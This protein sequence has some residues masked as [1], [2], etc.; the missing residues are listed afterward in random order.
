MKKFILVMLSIAMLLPALTYAQGVTSGAFG[1]AVIDVDGK[2]MPGVMVKALHIPTGTTYRVITNEKG[3][4]NIQGAVVGGPYK[5]TAE[6]EGFTTGVKDGLV[7]KLGEKK[8]LQ[9]MLQLGTI[10]EADIN[11][12]ASNPIIN[13]SRTGAA[14]NVSADTIMNLP[15]ISRSISD[16]TRLAPQFAS[17][18]EEGSFS[19]GGRSS[20]Y[21]NIQIDG[22]QNN[23]LFGLGD[24]GA[25]G[26]R[27]ESAPISLDAIQEFQIVLAP[28]DVRHGG[29]TGGGVNVIT[30]SGTNK[31]HGSAYFFGRNQSLVGNGPDD[32]AYS[33]MQESTIGLSIGGAI[34]KNK[35]F[36]FLS[37]EQ[38]KA[39]DK[40]DLD[41]YIDGSGNGY[42][43]GNKEDADRIIAAL[44]N[45]GYDA[46]GYGPLTNAKKNTKIFFRFDW[47][48]G[49]KHRLTLRHNF[50]DASK[51]VR[52]N[53][54][55]YSFYLE[56][57]GVI[58]ESKTNST[59]L[60]LMSTFSS[61]LFNE[62][63]LN[64]TTI[65][66]NPTYLG[67]AFPRIKVG[68]DANKTFIAGSEEY[69][70]KNELNQ[71]IFEFTNNLTMFSG[72]HK[73][74]LGTHNELISFYNVFIKRAYG[75]YEFDSIEDLE[76]GTPGK[77][78]R[79]YS[80]TD[81]PNAPAEFSVMQ[82]GFYAGDE[83]SVSDN[84]KLT[85]GLRAEVPIMND[86][87][88]ANPNVESSFGIKTDQNSGGN[89]V[90]SP[91]LGFNMSFGEDKNTQF[92]GGI[93]VFSGRPAY[94]W[95]SNQFS[96]TGTQ[97]GQYKVYDPDFFV[98][99]P[100]A[101][102]T[103]PNARAGGDINVIDDNFKFPQILRTNLAVDQNLAEGLTL[104][105]EMLYSKSMNEIYYEHINIGPNGSTGFDGR[106]LF[107]QQS[108]SGRSKYGRP[109]YLQSGFYNVVKLSNT[110]QGSEFSLSFQL[111]KE[112]GKGNMINASYTYGMA[113]SV[114]SGT[115]SQALSNW[116]YNVTG[117][118]PNEV[119]L[120]YSAH[121]TRHRLVLAVNKRF[122]FINN[123]PT[124]VS[125]VYIG[126]SGRPYSTV[127]YNDFNGDGFAGNDSIWVPNSESDVILLKGT[128]A[129]LDKYI[130][131]DP[132]LNSARGTILGRN[133]SRDPWSHVVDF[134]FS[135]AIPMPMFNGHK[136]ELTFTVKN[137]LNLFNKDWGVLRYISYNDAPLTYR[138]ID[139][140]TGKPM[141]EFWGKAADDE[142]YT[143]NQLLSR[144]KAMVGVRYSF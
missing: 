28:F 127:Y 7:I 116:K 113:K 111:Q 132:A 82:L 80:L 16:F 11:V 52:R 23:D 87:P 1:G 76:N 17:G 36:Y 141:V 106:P 125:F 58:Y 105:V 56:N 144:W 102:P 45:Y 64:Y 77:F 134:K 75:Q 38:E 91:R 48:L 89:V 98:T 71:D 118:N 143:I 90:F 55:T 69:R 119:E 22:A 33:D 104:T 114:F 96:N 81:D 19:A 25:P 138:G 2:A 8:D 60:Q 93:G 101:Q 46:G 21:N 5:V 66:D 31:L 20:R 121:D 40:A 73:I 99:D 12:T 136:L 139:E 29:F 85:F 88:E 117:W 9:F 78:E 10:K 115:S 54:S 13:A 57:A 41:Y 63:I 129:D 68:T 35:M 72:D 4:F 142:R 44:K 47:N 59:V 51:E 24:S 70:Q 95:I 110:D 97:L 67:E 86:T 39:D 37:V 107:G 74:T 108:T 34:V 42:D 123:A 112:W 27:T 94:V 3:Q 137:F 79:Y 65:R 6:L 126:R 32:I 122:E 131:D 135:Q 30:K 103:N 84:F 18:E 50:I 128:W 140:A 62:L 120:G 100:N 92:R 133:A 14:Q 130:T 15:T 83:W 53:N 109:D 43:F 26:A 49:E 61:T 124:N